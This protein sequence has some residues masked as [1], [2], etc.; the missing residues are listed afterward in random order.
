MSSYGTYLQDRILQA[1]QQDVRYMEI[2]HRLQQG[3]GI[4]IGTTVGTCVG[5]GIGSGIGTGIGI[6]AG[7]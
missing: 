6:G 2:V 4:G 3:V 1:S 5:I 7:A